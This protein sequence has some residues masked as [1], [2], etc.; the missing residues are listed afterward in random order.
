MHNHEELKVNSLIIR[1]WHEWFGFIGLCLFLTII[2]SSYDGVSALAVLLF[3]AVS[4][5]VIA[6]T[7]QNLGLLSWVAGIPLYYLIMFFGLPLLI[8]ILEGS[9]SV[10]D[11]EFAEA[12]FTASAGLFA[13][14]GGV[15]TIRLTRQSSNRFD[16]VKWKG[17]FIVEKPWVLALFIA[18]GGA[19]LLWSYF[20]GYFGLNVPE[21]E[22][23]NVA[24]AI[25]GLAFFLTIA[26]LVAWNRYFLTRNRQFLLLGI[27]STLIMFIIGVL[28]NSK[29]DFILPFLLIALSI[30]GISGKLPLKLLMIS[31]LIYVFVAFPFV[32]VSRYTILTSNAELSR[33]EVAQVTA[34]YLLSG[35]WLSQVD[36][37][38]SSSATASLGRGLME[39]FTKIVRET[40]KTTDFLYGQTFVQGMEVFVPR[41]I[42]PN[43]PS[44]NIGN[45][46]AHNYDILAPTDSVTNISPTYMGELYMNFGFTGVVVGMFIMGI[47]AVLVDR[48]MIV[49][50]NNWSMPFMVVSISWQESFLGHTFLPFIKNTAMLW[51][52]LI[53]MASIIPNKAYR[54]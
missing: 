37:F 43:K 27:A 23:G 53:L 15:V 12:L 10:T 28:G 41:F 44:L 5:G 24:G 36:S 18:M 13:F 25:S 50:R 2:F 49:V 26:H 3:V 21:E 39:Y 4:L 40:G 42:Y 34:K 45:W 35:D 54:S 47:I 16:L 31:L 38:K 52:F 32:T 17:F 48:H 22:V 14:W 30:W 7:R 20:F 19:S 46:T 11:G 1:T 6:S 33:I 8:R 29:T 51:L 9:D